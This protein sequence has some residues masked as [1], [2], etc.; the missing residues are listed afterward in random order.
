MYQ[1]RKAVD[2]FLYAVTVVRRSSQK[3]DRWISTYQDSP[4]LTKQ[5]SGWLPLYVMITFRPDI[6]YATA[7]SKARQQAKILLY[8]TWV[9]ISLIIAMLGRNQWPDVTLSAARALVYQG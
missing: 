9:V 1:I 4:F 5:L 6:N 3:L 2:N 7:V 8:V